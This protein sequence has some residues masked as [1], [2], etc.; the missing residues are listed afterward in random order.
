MYL[1]NPFVASH[2]Y[3]FFGVDGEDIYDL[4]SS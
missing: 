1:V 3:H 4:L 2:S